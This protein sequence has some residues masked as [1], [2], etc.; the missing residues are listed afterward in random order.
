[1]SA[2]LTNLVTRT[3]EPVVPLQPRLTPLFA[4]VSVP[5]HDPFPAPVE[6]TE[7]RLE[8]PEAA[9]AAPRLREPIGF[10]RTAIPANPT[11][12]FEKGQPL[13]RE[14]SR[15]T[16]PRE[17]AGRL[18]GAETPVNTNSDIREKVG[19]R[20]EGRAPVRPAL[21]V[22][23]RGLDA[24]V[25]QE[26]APTQSQVGET[27]VRREPLTP[28]E[29]Q[30]A[31]PS[32]VIGVPSEAAESRN[33]D[34]ERDRPR[35]RKLEES[36]RELSLS[37]GLEALRRDVQ[38]FREQYPSLAVKTSQHREEAPLAL[39]AAVVKPAAVHEV[40]ESRRDQGF[41]TRVLTPR[42]VE[43]SRAQQGLE[44]SEPTIHVTIGK[45]EV[46]TGP[47]SQPAKKGVTPSSTLSLNE[48][49]R[50]RSGRSRE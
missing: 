32:R 14:V 22:E 2:Y 41:P 3:I 1:M 5:S 34:V 42:Q 18:P 6:E 28:H 17:K 11:H 15:E 37:K 31:S 43:K 39:K 20:S 19:E 33:V 47:P 25:P 21:R 10:E 35:A 26:S 29:E 7:V 49:L 23:N 40:Q 9:V 8:R 38:R 44:G 45:I 50:Q 16:R 24:P 13:D 12:S 4:P 30:G 27:V 46:R 36:T 48:Y